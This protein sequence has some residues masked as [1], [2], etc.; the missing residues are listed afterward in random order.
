MS[1]S[2]TGGPPSPGRSSSRRSQQGNSHLHWH[3]AALPPEV[4]YREQQFHS[5]MTE[6]GVL[7]VSPEEAA[8][9]AARIRA[10]VRPWGR[11]VFSGSGVGSWGE[12]RVRASGGGWCPLPGY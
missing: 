9:V 7:A 4:P 1:P 8:D 2:S 10:A 6:N 5:L 12:S 11:G 3:I